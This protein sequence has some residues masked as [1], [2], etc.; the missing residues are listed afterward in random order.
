MERVVDAVLDEIAWFLKLREDSGRPENFDFYFEHTMGERRLER[1]LGFLGLPHDEAHPAA[2]GEAFRA[3]G[4]H[5]KEAR[6]VDLYADQ[7]NRKFQRYPEMR[8]ALLRFAHQ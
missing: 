7:V 8:E 3:S 6:I 1:L 5:P 4:E 2:A